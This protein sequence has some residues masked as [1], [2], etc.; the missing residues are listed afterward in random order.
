MKTDKQAI[1]QDVTDRVIRALEAGT[2]PWCCPWDRTGEVT[3]PINQ[4]TGDF[5]RGINIPLLWMEQHERGFASSRWMTYRQAQA[6]D[7]QVR[8]GEKGT[9]I[10]FFKSLERG[11][12]EIDTSTGETKTDRIPMLRT[13]TVFN[14]DQIEGIDSPVPDIQ[15]EG[16]DPIQSAEGMLRAS[17]V[18]IHEGGSR[19]FYRPSSDEITLPDRARFAHAYNFYATALHELSHATGHKDRCDRKPYECD[20][21]KTQY[22]FEE[23][24]A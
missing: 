16:F 10:V 24:V 21:Q 20:H 12:G 15:S 17:G 14:L 9:T 5:Y 22:A 19:A 3:L 7:A 18:V 1:Y 6:K 2:K 23:L 8:K 4:S 11:T 13:F